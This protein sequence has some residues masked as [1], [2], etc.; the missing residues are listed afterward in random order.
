M[1]RPGIYQIVHVESGRRYIG[2]SAKV[3]A[4][5]SGHRS[6]LRRGCHGNSR[7][8][9]AWNKY[10]ESAFAFEVIEWVDDV[11]ALL[12]REQVH[13]VSARPL[14]FNAGIEVRRPT[15][16]VVKGPMPE[17]Q[18]ANIAA[19]LKGKKKPPFT[20]AHLAN[21]SRARSGK[22]HPYTPEQRAKIIASNIARTGERHT[23]E[24]RLKISAA[25]T[26]RPG[27]VMSAEGR[28]RLSEFAKRRTYSPETRAKM[29]AS[30]KARCARDR[31]A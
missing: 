24:A 22:P 14:V 3:G 10:G 11:L 27:P 5:F 19:A 6:T 4:R 20:A 28:A 26:G 23:V 16:G 17:V 18:R 2:S 13:L 7:L 1:N 9:N 15:F 29:S 8:Q 25:L 30:A 12:E 31:A 21:L